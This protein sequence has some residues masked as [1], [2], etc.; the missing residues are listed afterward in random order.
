MVVARKQYDYD[1]GKIKDQEKKT[2][3]RPRP[4]RNFRLEKLIFTMGIILVLS[5]SLVLLLRYSSITKSRHQVHT[6]NNKLD[7]LKV[8][9]EHLRIKLETVSKSRWIEE[10]AEDR[11]SMTYPLADQIL[12]IHVPADEIAIVS[13]EMHYYNNSKDT[14]ITSEKNT[15]FSF[16]GKIAGFFKI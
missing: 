11:L 4:V 8:Q 6:L 10:L 13:E 3:K 1:Q 5:L 16:I 14:D 9:K 7:Q 2:S 15:V 12:Y